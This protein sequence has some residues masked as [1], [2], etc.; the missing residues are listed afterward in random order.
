MTT[1]LV[2]RSVEAYWIKAGGSP[3]RF[4]PEQ[5]KP[6]GLQSKKVLGYAI[7]TASKEFF[8]VHDSERYTADHR[9]AQALA[10]TLSTEVLWF[11][12]YG[13]TDSAIARW[14]GSNRKPPRDSYDEV[15]ELIEGL[16]LDSPYLGYD[17]L[18][19]KS[20][21]ARP[22]IQWAAFAVAPKQYHSGPEPRPPRPRKG[23]LD[24]IDWDHQEIT[25][26]RASQLARELEGRLKSNRVVNDPCFRIIENLDAAKE[27]NLFHR[28]AR[29]AATRPVLHPETARSILSFFDTPR[30]DS[31]LFLAILS[32][33]A[34]FTDPD[35]LAS[36]GLTGAENF[37]SRGIPKHLVRLYQR[38]ALHMERHTRYGKFEDE[39][40]HLALI[41]V[42]AL[43]GNTAKALRHTKIALRLPGMYGTDIRTFR[44]LLRSQT[45][46]VK[47]FLASLK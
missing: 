27:R 5:L 8:A 10:R 26:V 24:T 46:D 25:Y 28:L 29:I 34:D 14:F 41:V 17:D 40:A 35:T 39:G 42:H 43:L 38:W 6:L 36:I 45:P 1:Q 30:K 7:R 11:A 37:H 21:S 18:A 16:K 23:T 32:R 15:A 4:K 44:P 13:A 2:S 12:L 19:G 33:F 20:A 47:A 9:L 31:E 3:K 22:N